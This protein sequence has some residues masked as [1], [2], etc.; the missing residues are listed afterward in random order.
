MLIT[1]NIMDSNILNI[2]QGHMAYGI[3]TAWF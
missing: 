2:R 3:K 1:L